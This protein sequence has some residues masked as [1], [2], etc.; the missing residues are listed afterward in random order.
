MRPDPM[1]DWSELLAV[2]NVAD[3]TSYTPPVPLAATD[4]EYLRGRSRPL[5]FKKKKNRYGP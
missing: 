1:N 4:K 3:L 5:H 2:L